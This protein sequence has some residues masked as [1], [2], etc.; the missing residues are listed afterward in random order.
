L[1]NVIAF[2]DRHEYSHRTQKR[3]HQQSIGLT[4]FVSEAAERS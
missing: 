2:L 1:L 3:F 4:R